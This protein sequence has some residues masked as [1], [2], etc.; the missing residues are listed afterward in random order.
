MSSIWYA[1]VYLCHG[2]RCNQCLSG[3]AVSY[4]LTGIATFIVF[5]RNKLLRF[6][7]VIWDFGETGRILIYDIP[8]MAHSAV[9]CLGYIVFAGIVARLGTTVFAA[10][11]IAVNAETLFYISCYGLRTAAQTLVGISAGEGNRKKFE[12]TASVSIVTILFM[13]AVSGAGPCSIL[14]LRLLWDFSP[15]AGRSQSLVREC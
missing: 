14:C 5:K 15:R 13:M 7:K 8:L 9:S 1:Y 10:H 4:S 11:S 12:D 2:S 6:D 3:T